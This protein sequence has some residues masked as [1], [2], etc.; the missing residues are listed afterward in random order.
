LTAGR[1]SRPPVRAIASLTAAGSNRRGGRPQRG[2]AASSRV[3]VERQWEQ[4]EVV[5]IA[6][7]LTHGARASFAFEA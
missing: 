1:R 7:C 6:A 2:Q 4:R 5:I 3:T